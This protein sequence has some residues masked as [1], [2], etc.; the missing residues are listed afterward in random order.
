MSTETIT[1]PLKYAGNLFDREKDFTK[2]Y[3]VTNNL[4]YLLKKLC[5]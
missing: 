4:I 5:N 2:I 3:I 1:E